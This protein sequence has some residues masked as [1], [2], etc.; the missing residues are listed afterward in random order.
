MRGER[1]EAVDDDID[2]ESFQL[3]RLEQR[4][5]REAEMM[6][7]EVPVLARKVAKIRAQDHVPTAGLECDQDL[8][9]EFVER[10][11]VGKML[12]K[13]RREHDVRRTRDDFAEFRGAAQM[14]LDALVEVA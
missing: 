14:E 8:I 12:E 9:E 11:L 10:L 1:K 6:I 3:Q 4:Q 7:V 2:V 13:I 5:M